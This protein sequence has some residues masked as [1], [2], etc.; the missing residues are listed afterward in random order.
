MFYYYY[1][2]LGWHRKAV[3]SKKKLKQYALHNWVCFYWHLPLEK[4]KKKGICEITEG[5]FSEVY[6]QT[7]LHVSSGAPNYD[8]LPNTFKTVLRLSWVLLDLWK[9]I[10]SRASKFLSVR[11]SLGNLSLFEITRVSV[12]FFR[13]C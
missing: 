8:F 2:S 12:L 7:D 5:V 9:C 11:S 13:K 6:S 3:L 1:V 10:P 4:D